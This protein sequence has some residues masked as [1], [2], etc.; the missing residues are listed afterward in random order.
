MFVHNL[1][2]SDEKRIARTILIQQSQLKTSNYYNDIKDTAEKLGVTISIEELQETKKS[3]WKHKLKEKIHKQILLDI[4]NEVRTKTKMR[5]VSKQT[6]EAEEY[7]RKLSM[8]EVATIMK[9]K[10]NM[11][12]TKANF[13]RGDDRICIMC[14]ETDETTEH[15]FK[16]PKYQQLTGHTLTWDKNRK[17]WLDIQWLKKAAM[18]VERIEEIR[19]REVS[20]L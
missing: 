17:H 1:I 14:K 10:L 7:I 8:K 2:N 18:V 11:V 13:P 3:A 9:L 5:F 15:L 12:E 16:C 6:F 20:R 4:K 19:E